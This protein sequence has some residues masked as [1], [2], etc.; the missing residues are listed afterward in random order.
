MRTHVMNSKSKLV[1]PPQISGYHFVGCDNPLM[2]GDIW[3]APYVD[4][5]TPWELSYGTRM[6]QEVYVGRFLTGNANDHI[7]GLYRPIFHGFVPLTNEEELI[8]EGD[9]ALMSSMTSSILVTV[10]A[11]SHL[12]AIGPG[13]KHIGKTVNIFSKWGDYTIWRPVLS[14]PRQ[15]KGNKHYSSPLPLP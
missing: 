11:N 5:G 7:H 9:M 14:T 10:F 1:L 3:F 2:I 15:L 12:Y 8:C 4:L 6:D 13:H